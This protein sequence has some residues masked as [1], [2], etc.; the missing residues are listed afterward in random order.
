MNKSLQRLVGTDAKMIAK[1]MAGTIRVAS[2]SGRMV[3]VADARAVAALEQAFEAMLL[4]GEPVAREISRAAGM[5]FPQALGGAVPDDCR[6]W[7]AVGIDVAGAPTCCLRWVHGA[8][9]STQPGRIVVRNTVLRELAL[10][11]GRPGLAP[12]GDAP[13]G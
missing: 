13:C 12:W 8:A 11:I 9:L 4:I 2:A 10:L 5:T 3:L 6:P 1:A 7:L